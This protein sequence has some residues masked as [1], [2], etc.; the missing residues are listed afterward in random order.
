MHATRGALLAA[1]NEQQ[2]LS[3]GII[4]CRPIQTTLWDVRDAVTRTKDSELRA[5]LQHLNGGESVDVTDVRVYVDNGHQHYVETWVKRHADGTE[6]RVM[7]EDLDGCDEH[8]LWMVRHPGSKPVFHRAG[9]DVPA[10]PAF[11]ILTYEGTDD[12]PIKCRVEYWYDQGGLTKYEKYEGTDF[13]GK[14]GVLVSTEPPAD[15]HDK[16]WTVPVFDVL[17]KLVEKNMVNRGL[18]L[19][20]G[21]NVDPVPFSV[22]GDCVAGGLYYCDAEDVI[23]WIQCLNYTHLCTVTVPANAQTVQLDKKYRSDRIILGEPYPIA[24]HPIW[25]DLEICKRV[26]QQDGNALRYVKEQTEE[27]CKLAVQ[28]NGWALR[29][30]KEQ[31]EELCRL[32]VQQNGKALR[33]VNEHTEELCRL[34]VQRNG[35]AL[36]YVKE[37]T[38]ELCKLAVQQDGV[39]LAHVREQTVEVC[40]LAVQRDRRAIAHVREQTEE[41]RQLAA[42]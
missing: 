23:E 21:L 13:I 10:R 17:V 30:V 3:R 38:E 8:E 41:L 35:Q 1:V 20:V 7:F 15:R 40:K 5:I 32:A 39:A 27:I 31:T 34:A 19:E 11:T 26:V 22:E 9:T 36:R 4:K 18:Q 16:T 33:Y 25:S 28:Q 37:Q 42:A 6:Y 24:K 12:D 14:G 2:P 29:Y